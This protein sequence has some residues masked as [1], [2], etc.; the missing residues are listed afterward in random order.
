MIFKRLCIKVDLGTF[1]LRALLC[2]SV[3][4]ALKPHTNRLSM[5]VFITISKNH[6]FD[7]KFSH[8]NFQI[9]TKVNNFKVIVLSA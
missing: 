1:D 7:Q 5:S 2:V 4:I 3:F 8:M 9:C 6:P